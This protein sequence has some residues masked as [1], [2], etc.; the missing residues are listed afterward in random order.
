MTDKPKTIQEALAEVQSKINE[1]QKAKS[2]TDWSDEASYKGSAPEPE[3]PEAPKAAP[4]PTTPKST[5]A[6]KAAAPTTP[7]AKGPSRLKVGVRGGL[8]GLALGYAASRPEVQDAAVKAAGWAKEKAGQAGD[9]LKDKAQKFDDNLDTLNKKPEAPATPASSTPTSA[10]ADKTPTKLPDIDVK[11]APKSTAKPMSFS[12]AFKTAREK[13]TTAGH[14]STGQFEYQGKKFQTNVAGE[15]YVP[16]AQQTSVEPK[17]DNVPLPPKRPTDLTPKTETES[18]K[19]KKMSEENNPLISAFLKLQDQAPANMFEA[20]KKAKKDYDKDGK[21]ESPKDEVWG[22]R[23]RAAKA[24]GKMEE[25]VKADPNDPSYQGGGDVTSTPE[26]KTSMPKPT[27]PKTDSSVQGSGD[28]TMNGKPTRVKEEVTFSQAEIDH[29]NSFFLEASVAPN[30]PEVATG[31]DSTSDKMS[32]ND[33]TGTS[34]EDGKKKLKEETVQEADKKSQG[35]QNWPG[36]KKKKFFSGPKD[37]DGKTETQKWAEKR[38]SEKAAKSVKE[39]TLQEGRPRKNPTPETTE[40]DPRK[41]IQV[42]AGRAAAGNV[43]DFTHNDGSKSKITP[44]MGR[45]ITSHLQS[46]KPADRQTA[47]NKMHDSAEGLKV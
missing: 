17:V 14:P 13:A 47:V 30:R 41:H 42:E 5:A 16:A 39:E 19:K 11:A 24:A 43:V 4:K 20:A 45:K 8:A 29:I 36:E 40:R 22:S 7:V 9:W 6:P 33:V 18:G 12:Q 28:V 31:A 1:A 44:A 2:T 3:A 26:K 32:Q 46:L 10:P 15:K 25:G 27:A 23:F 21:V 34:T 35:Y 38:A 37:A